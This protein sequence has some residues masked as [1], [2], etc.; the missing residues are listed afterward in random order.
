MN[1][2]KRGNNFERM[3]Y[4]YLQEELG[5]DNLFVPQKTSKIF[6]KKAYFSRD[7]QKQYS[8]GYFDRN[9]HSRCR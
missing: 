6:Q 8:N 5:K 3:V 9:F 2:T 1:A 7:R 4:A